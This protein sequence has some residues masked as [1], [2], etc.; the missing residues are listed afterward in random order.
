M[1][2][3]R[4]H[5]IA[6]LEEAIAAIEARRL[7]APELA[8]ENIALLRSRIAIVESAKESSLQRLFMQWAKDDMDAGRWN[9]DEVSS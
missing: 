8:D 5:L 2:T 6:A 3:T 1:K 4:Q 7:E 9:P